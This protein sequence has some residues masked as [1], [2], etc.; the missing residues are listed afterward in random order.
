MQVRRG[1]GEGKRGLRER[2][3]GVAGEG[4]RIEV[5]LLDGG[6]GQRGARGAD[7]QGNDGMEWVC[8]RGRVW[9]WV[10]LRLQ[11][12]WGFVFRGIGV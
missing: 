7:G 8:W 2:E 9:S 5:G 1:W 12:C 10:G 6:G 4:E 3:R 11:S